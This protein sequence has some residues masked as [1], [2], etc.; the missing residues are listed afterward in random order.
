MNTAMNAGNIKEAKIVMIGSTTVGKTS[1]T[2][3]LTRS[4]FV[5][6]TT[7]TIGASFQSKVVSVGEEQVKL[8][9]WDTGGSERYRAMAPMYYRDAQAA[10]IVYDITSKESF[11]DVE[12][13]LLEL[14]E[15][16][17]KGCIIALVGNK[18]DLSASRQVSTQQAQNYA[19]TKKVNI[20][21]ETSA[22]NGEN[23][24]ELFQKVAEYVF[25]KPIIQET[26]VSLEK[27][28]SE[29]DNVKKGC[30]A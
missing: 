24:N 12:T 3:R 17:P 4:Q 2:I 8:Q 19:D 25:N 21:F 30:C 14:K 6:S 13:W 23:I 26:T 7:S 1:I 20:F 11:D 29:S 27:S 28:K 15:K 5:E 18:S 9:I 22:L 10:V 16:G